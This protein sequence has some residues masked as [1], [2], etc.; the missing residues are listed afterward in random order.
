MLCRLCRLQHIGA[1]SVTAYWC[2]VGYEELVSRVFQGAGGR[3]RLCVFVWCRR[4]GMQEQVTWKAL[5][6]VR[7]LQRYMLQAGIVSNPRLWWRMPAPEHP[8]KATE[9]LL[10]AHC[11]PCENAPRIS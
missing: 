6:E 3:E 2:L 8:Q 4:S 1:L 11:L 9:Q 10:R 7:D 5:P